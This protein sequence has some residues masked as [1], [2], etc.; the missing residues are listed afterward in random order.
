MRVVPQMWAF[1]IPFTGFTTIVIMN[2]IVGVMVGKI[3]DRTRI[4]EREQ[5]LFTDEARLL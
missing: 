3:M 1:F 4:E 5:Q 2:L